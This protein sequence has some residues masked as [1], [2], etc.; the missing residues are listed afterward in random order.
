M[1]HITKTHAVEA[2]RLPPKHTLA[3]TV[4]GKKT[5]GASGDWLTVTATHPP[6]FALVSDK[7]FADRFE[8]AVVAVELGAP[9]KR[10]GPAPGKTRG[11]GQAPESDRA[12]AHRPL[13]RR[14]QR[15][16]APE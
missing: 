4:D 8:P 15:P 3:L 7:E 12:A 9:T 13:A 1:R 5:L 16:R 10:R 14:Q 2:F 11:G 6:A